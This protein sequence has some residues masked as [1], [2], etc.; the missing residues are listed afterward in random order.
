MALRMP[1]YLCEPCNLR[2]EIG[3]V[4]TPVPP[5]SPCPECGAQAD[6]VIGASKWAREWVSPVKRGKPQEVAGPLSMDTRPI[7]EGKMTTRE[8]TAMMQ[9]R[10]RDRQWQEIKRQLG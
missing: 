9:K 3:V 8:W 2:F 4:E 10:A 1:D 7:A 6:H 5:T